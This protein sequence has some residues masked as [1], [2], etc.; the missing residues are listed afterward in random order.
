M[1]KKNVLIVSELGAL[2]TILE[3]R[4]KYSPVIKFEKG[5]KREEFNKLSKSLPEFI[6][7]R[8]NHYVRCILKTENKKQVQ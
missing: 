4:S 2:K 6:L 7:L 5:E 1:F 3:P 8:E